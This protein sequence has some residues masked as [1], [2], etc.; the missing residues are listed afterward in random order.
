M[1]GSVDAMPQQS[2]LR[3][4]ARRNRSAIVQAAREAFARHGLQASLDD[5]AKSAGV[6]SGTLYR[7][8]PKRDDLVGEV[9]TE[10]M[11]ELADTVEQAK[12][13]PDPW[14]GFADC[15]RRVCGAQAEDRGLAAIFAIGQGG[16]E[17]A[18]LRGR[19]YAGFIELVDA[20]KA[21]GELREDFTAEDVAVLLMANAGIIDRADALAVDASERFV[22]LALDGFRVQG[23]TAAPPAITPRRLLAVLRPRR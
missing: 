5:I 9:F 3:A 6:G 12:R 1:R 16:P 22:A 23:A 7:H 18:G 2:A 17:L 10:R 14:N 13:D 4:D 20:A 15:V 11:A 8:F 19:A 21:R